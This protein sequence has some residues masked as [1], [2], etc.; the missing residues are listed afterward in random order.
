MT[1][2]GPDNGATRRGNVGPQWDHTPWRGG[3]GVADTEGRAT[4]RR[5]GQSG[6]GPRGNVGTKAELRSVAVWWLQQGTR[7]GRA[8]S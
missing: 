2:S 8:L 3:R 1:A 7:Q 4:W 6:V 5:G